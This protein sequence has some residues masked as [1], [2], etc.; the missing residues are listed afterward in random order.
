MKGQR[1]YYKP[2]EKNFKRQISNAN[3]KNIHLKRLKLCYSIKIVPG[4]RSN[5]ILKIY[6][7][8]WHF[9]NT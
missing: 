8:M 4:G 3:A 2:R 6:A 1:R 7:V 9:N 5:A